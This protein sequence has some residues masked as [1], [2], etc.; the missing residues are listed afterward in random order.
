MSNMSQKKKKL[1]PRH[2]E[3]IDLLSMCFDL[4]GEESNSDIVDVA[5][6]VQERH[7]PHGLCC[8]ECSLTMRLKSIDG[9]DKTLGKAWYCAQCG[10]QTFDEY[11]RR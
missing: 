4:G 7:I 10:R 5:E 1:S 8:P 6:V 2:V 3:Q 9:K 11:G